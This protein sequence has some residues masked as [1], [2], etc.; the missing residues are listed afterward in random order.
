MYFRRLGPVT[1]LGD[2]AAVGQMQGI[3]GMATA[4]GDV[5]LVNPSD[6]MIDEANN[7]GFIG[8]YQ[9]ADVIV[10]Q[11]AYHQGTTTPVLDPDW[12]YIVPG[13]VSADQ[14]NL[15]IVNEGPVNS[16]E[17]QNIDDMVFEVRLDQWFGCGFVKGKL[18][19]IGAY[20]IG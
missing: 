8:R 12:L 11:N 2:I 7:N 3:T 9:G 5:L 10:L 6:N 1:V 19:N 17:S 15:K 16:F 4:T 20:K 14:R 13:G 18:P